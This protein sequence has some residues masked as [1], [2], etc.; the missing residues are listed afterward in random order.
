[1]GVIFPRHFKS[2]FDEPFLLA[3]LR[4]YPCTDR[5]LFLAICWC[6]SFVFI[7]SEV[8][9]RMFIV[10]FN[11]TNFSTISIQ[12]ER[13]IVKKTKAPSRISFLVWIDICTF[14]T[15]N[16]LGDIRR[17]NIIYIRKYCLMLISNLR[18]V[19]QPDIAESILKQWSC[20]LPGIFI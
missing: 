7:S 17:V 13:T 2:L 9:N 4:N 1:M 11:V 6:L 3:V 14:I 16:S 20:C 12:V 15:Y 5:Y 18:I 19:S 8:S 10:H